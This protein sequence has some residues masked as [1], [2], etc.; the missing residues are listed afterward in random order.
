[1]AN[2]EPNTAAARSDRFAFFRRI[3]LVI[4]V[5]I[6][7]ALA[8]IFLPPMWDSR[9][10]G[11]VQAPDG[12]FHATISRF[13]K[14]YDIERVETS[15]SGQYIEFTISMFE[16]DSKQLIANYSTCGHYR[17]EGT[18]LLFF[19]PHDFHCGF[20]SAPLNDIFSPRVS[21]I[22]FSESGATPSFLPTENQ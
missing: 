1:V 13:G 22:E 14:T 10:L 12:T 17:D 11:F 6:V 7:A 4:L 21:R 18:Q 16:S 19:E 20:I 2:A 8:K 15:G 3:N 5:I 9:T